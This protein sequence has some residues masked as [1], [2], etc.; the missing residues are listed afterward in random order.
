LLVEDSDDDALLV[1]HELHRGGYDPR[2]HR[3]T[4]RGEFRE[5]LDAGPWDVIIS[6][7]TLPTYDGMSALTDL[8][9]TSKDIPF[10]LVSG[11]IGEAVAVSAMKAGAQD[12]VLKG[13]LT[14]LPVAVERELRE[15]EVRAE[16]VRMR[17]QLVISERMA[18]AGTLA[19]GVAHEINNPLA[20]AFSNL[21]F[22]SDMIAEGAASWA[23]DGEKRLGDAVADAREALDR[24]RLIVRDVKL[25]SRPQDQH[26]GHVDVARVVDSAARMAW[27][28]IRHR[29][30]LVK[31]YRPTPLALA[32]ESRIG[33]VV[34]NLIVNAAQ[35]MPEGHADSHEL[36]VTTR[37]GRNGQAVLE[38]ADTGSGIPKEHIERIFDP[39]FTT[40]PVGVGTGLGLSICQRIVIQL[41][42]TIEV[43]SEVGR[44][45]L[46]RVRL[47]AAPSEP[48]SSEPPST[49]PAPMARAR[50]LLVDDEPAIGR[51][52]TRALEG[53]H[54]VEATA[55]GRALLA[56]IAAGE[57]FD[58]IISDLMMPEMT[59][60]D[61]HA[62]LRSVAPDQAERMVFLT[63][64]AFTSRARDFLSTVENPVIE[65]PLER[66]DLVGAIAAM[67][68][69]KGRQ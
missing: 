13:D 60:M 48:R 25:F 3:V 46:F 32:N 40:K 15:R 51:V 68:E 62:E 4:T 28:E 22:V 58:V 16:Q 61:L 12:Y 43:H 54:D 19:A 21:E 59:G 10:I 36:R 2:V 11:T 65:K 23:N 37:T 30:R 24:I 5:A 6:D 55:S 8:R 52:L 38:V 20:V 35:A 67:L 64:G 44:G 42:G 17:E 66:K 31:D 47:P 45:S 26:A 7:H 29:A 9:E 41:G 56:R 27:N 1:L 50:V 53:L 34:L 49:P 14:R 39:F 33:Q 69:R 57:R 63:G 18:S